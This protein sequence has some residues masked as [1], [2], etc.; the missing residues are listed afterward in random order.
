MCRYLV[1]YNLKTPEPVIIIFGTQYPV[2]ISL[3]KQL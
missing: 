1:F 2:N 3:W